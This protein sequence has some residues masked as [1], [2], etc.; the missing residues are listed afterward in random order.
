M[1]PRLNRQLVLERSVR[2]ANGSGGYVTTWSELGTLWA[3]VLPGASSSTRLGGLTVHRQTLKISVRGVAIGRPSRPLPGQ[4]FR[5]GA[6]I[7]E[8]EAVTE[9]DA[10]GRFLVCT[11]REEVTS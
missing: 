9:R 5:D 3:E 8:I 6:R 10:E 1:I 7:Y 2:S 4:R 11:A